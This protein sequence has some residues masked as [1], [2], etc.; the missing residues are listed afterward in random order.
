MRSIPCASG[1]DCGRCMDLSQSVG[2]EQSQSQSADY[3]A[4]RALGLT[5][6]RGWLFLTEQCIEQEDSRQS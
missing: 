4:V 5:R 6:R 2:Q 1:V 3:V